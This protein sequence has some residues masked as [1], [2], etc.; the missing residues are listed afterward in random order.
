[1][2]QTFVALAIAIFTVVICP[3][4]FGQN[5]GYVLVNNDNFKRNSVTAFKVTATG[6]LS[7]FET[8]ETDGAGIGGGFFVMSNVAI[9][10]TAHCEAKSEFT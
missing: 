9:E 4:S 10:S 2:R 1:M 8:L 6:K 3:V 7:S 5:G